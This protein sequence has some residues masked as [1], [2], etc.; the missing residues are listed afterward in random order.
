MQTVHKRSDYQFEIADFGTHLDMDQLRDIVTRSGSHFFDRDTMRF[1]K[2]RAD[3]QTFA[4]Q[5]GWYFVTSEKH[6][7]A[8]ARIN[9]PRL[10][11]VRCL[12]IVHD[13]GNVPTLRM[14][15]LEGFQ[16]Y[17]TLNSARTAARKAS[18]TPR[19][20]CPSCHLRLNADNEQSTCT[21]CSER[22][23]RMMTAAVNEGR[24]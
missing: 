11:T 2:S 24:L 23:D 12:R 5:D 7:S 3:W 13:E 16:H 22:H 14:V 21:E 20:L 18:K 9:E 6:E 10:Y 4:G 19:S 17:R 15:D 1:F 8:F